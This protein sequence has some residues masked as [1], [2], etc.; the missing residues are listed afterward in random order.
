LPAAN[1][2]QE[3]EDQQR[4]PG[5]WRGRPL[6]FPQECLQEYQPLQEQLAAVELPQDEDEEAADEGVENA[7]GLDAEGQYDEG[8]EEEDEVEDEEEGEGASASSSEE[9]EEEEVVAQL[10]TGGDEQQ[11]AASKGMAQSNGAPGK[12]A[13]PSFE[14]DES[15]GLAGL[16]FDDS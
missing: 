3:Q 11:E 12:H 4:L 7:D 6:L 8:E 16:E 13:P 5:Q 15:E 10:S 1:L 14:D 2:G 9:E